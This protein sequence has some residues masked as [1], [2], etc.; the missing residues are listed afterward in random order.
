M[1]HGKILTRIT[2]VK[3]R[4]I[5]VNSSLSIV[6]ESNRH[7]GREVE[8]KGRTA[9]GAF[10]RPLKEQLNNQGLSECV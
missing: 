6:V 3:V 9:E 7:E 10:E 1:N 4:K 2:I 5:R 8:G